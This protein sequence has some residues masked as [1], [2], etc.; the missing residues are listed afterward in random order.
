MNSAFK[1]IRSGVRA[2]LLVFM[3]AVCAWTEQ[4]SHVRIVRLSFAQG[5]VAIQRPDTS[6]WAKAPVNTPIQQGFKIS[7]GSS[8]FAEVEFENGSTAR[9]GEGSLLEFNQLALAASGETINRLTLI[10]GYASLHV[11]ADDYQVRAQNTALKP[12]GKTEFRADLW[13][14]KLRVEVFKGMVDVSGPAGSTTL[15]KNN[16]L[17][18]A[19]G[20]QDAYDVS[21]GIRKDA[22]DKWVV[23]RDS[24]LEAN[25]QAPSPYRNAP[26]Y[27]WSDLNYYGTWSDY[28]GYGYGWAPSVAGLWSPFSSGQWAWYPGFGYTWIGSEPWAWLPY[29]YGNWLF[30]SNSGWFWI[31]GGFANGWSPATVNWYQGPGWIGWAP[32]AVATTAKLG[33]SSASTNAAVAGK[34]CPPGGCVTA[35]SATDF[36]SGKPVTRGGGLTHAG[37]AAAT[38]VA[39][40]TVQPTHFALLTGPVLAEAPSLRAPSTAPQ[41]SGR[42]RADVEHSASLG[43]GTGRQPTVSGSWQRRS[44]PSYSA[45]SQLRSSSYPTSFSSGPSS[46]RSTGGSLTGG[47]ISS[48][49]G[50][51]SSRH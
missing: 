51:S 19:P 3:A 47:V 18:L 46:G 5:T 42:P 7:T 17:E 26:A 20:T 36:S 12:K 39:Q 13:Q 14:G 28:P 37:L 35:I 48:H 49:S 22:W 29:H 21:R 23:R 38:L 24:E 31:P 43:G 34:N 2:A 16:V 32:A 4:Y 45:H 27:G 25:S 40:P 8:S 41:S 10:Q 1:L 44:A 9:I 30:N 11:S 15:A 33:S 6:E 50:N